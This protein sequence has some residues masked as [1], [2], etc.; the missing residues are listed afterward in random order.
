MQFLFLKLNSVAHA[1]LYNNLLCP[2]ER[3]KRLVALQAIHRLDSQMHVQPD[4]ARARI[5]NRRRQHDHT[6]PRAA[7]IDDLADDDNDVPLG[8]IEFRPRLKV[9]CDFSSE[10][11]RERSWRHNSS[12]NRHNSGSTMRW[13]SRDSG[14]SQWPRPETQRSA[15]VSWNSSHMDRA[16]PKLSR[17]LGARMRHTTEAPS[18]HREA[19]KERYRVRER[20]RERAREQQGNARQQRTSTKRG[21]RRGNMVFVT[22]SEESQEEDE[23]SEEEEQVAVKRRH[24]RISEDKVEKWPK[25]TVHVQ[26]DDDDNFVL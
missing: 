14:T 20:L 6:D 18:R 3:T 22:D 16:E 5:Q 4:D 12:S 24:R 1:L 21:V 8:N 11:G 17:R 2:R 13:H 26:S 23:A 15:G 9:S 25:L 19:P 10:A 7:D